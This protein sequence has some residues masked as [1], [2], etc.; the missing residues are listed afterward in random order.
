MDM[1]DEKIRFNFPWR[2]PSVLAAKDMLSIRLVGCE[3]HLSLPSR[4][5]SLSWLEMGT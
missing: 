3:V 5:A 2:L 4:E 1:R